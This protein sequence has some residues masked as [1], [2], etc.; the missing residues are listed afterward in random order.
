M[1]KSFRH[2]KIPDPKKWVELSTIRGKD[3]YGWFKDPDGHYGF[4]ILDAGWAGAHYVTG[5]W[6]WVN[7][8]SC[9]ADHGGD[10]Q[11]DDGW[12]YSPAKVPEI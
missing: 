2:A 5:T 12:L 10:V 3:N 4:G 8:P 7:H 11:W 1:E 9:A 6:V